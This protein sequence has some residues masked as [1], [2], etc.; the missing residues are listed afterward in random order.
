[1]IRQ[2]PTMTGS[3]AR[4]RV[5]P[6]STHERVHEIDMP[7]PIDLRLTGWISRQ[8]I[9]PRRIVR[10]VYWLWTKFVRPYE[11]VH[12]FVAIMLSG[13]VTD[14]EFAER[15][16]VCDACTSQVV[17]EG[18]GWRSGSY[19]LACKCPRW[20]LARLARKNWKQRH[21]CPERKHPGV[22]PKQGCVG[23]GGSTNG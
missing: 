16:E 11:R 20:P 17:V 12:E 3:D 23:C 5:F 7:A 22:Y 2:S 6:G 19:C 4:S 9:T 13:R 14:E 8:I 18:V 21:R 1:M 15:Q 10:L